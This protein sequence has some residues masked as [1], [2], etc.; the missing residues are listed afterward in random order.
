MNSGKRSRSNG[1]DVRSVFLAVNKDGPSLRFRCE[2]V[3]SEKSAH[4]QKVVDEWRESVLGY[5]RCGIL[6]LVVGSR[7]VEL[8]LSCILLKGRREGRKKVLKGR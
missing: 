3:R 2:I 8:L 4:S 5:L 1:T 6:E 7:Q